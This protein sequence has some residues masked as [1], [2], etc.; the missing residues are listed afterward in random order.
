[1]RKRD[2]P[3]GRCRA[4]TRDS[5]KLNEELGE[6]NGELSRLTEEL[7]FA[8]DYAESI[9][10]SARTPLIILDGALKVRSVNRAF[11]EGFRVT[12]GET[13]GRYIYDLGNR[14]WAIPELRRLLEEV[15]PLAQVIEDYEIRHTF[16]HLGLRIMLLTAR[17]LVQAPAREPLIILSIE[18][19]TERDQGREDALSELNALRHFQKFSALLVRENLNGEVYEHILSTAV[20]LMGA[21]MASMQMLDAD[22]E[23]LRLLAWRGFHPES[24]AH[25]ER[26]PVGSATSCGAAAAAAGRVFVA[27]IESRT[28]LAGTADLAEFRRSGI[29]ACQST[30]LISRAG[31][32]LGMVSTH[33][34]KPH[35]PVE[36][37]LRLL[38][39]LARQA[40][41][42]IERM[43]VQQAL[44]A[45][46][47]R[48]R[49][50]FDL[51]PVAVYSCNTS[52]V[53]EK[54]NSQ[55]AQ[56]WGRAPALG[57][58][59]ERF[60]GSFKMFRPDGSFMTHDQCPMAEVLSGKI[61]E[62]HDGEVLIHR[63]DG[64][65]VTVIVNIRP[66][67]NERGEVVGA[68][69]C[70]YDITERNKGE[71][72]RARLAAIVESSDDAIIGKNLDGIITSWNA[73]AERIF[74]YTAQEIVGQSVTVLIP[75][76]RFAEEAN[77]LGHIRRGE[78]I[79]HF[80][81]VR[82]RKDGTLF[83]VSLTTSPIVD[84]AGR[85]VG[86]SKIARDITAGKR[87]AEALL[88]SEERYRSII[89]SSPDC[90]KVLDLEGNLLSLE[91]GLELLG[92]K[93]I[94]PLL[95][96]SWIEFWKGGEDRA[97]AVAA[98]A[99]AAAGG[100]GEFVG[101][102]RTL[103]GL[104]KWWDVA[105]TPV[106]DASGQPVRLL[107]VSRDVT[108]RHDMEGLLAARTAA[109]VQAD[110]SKDEFLAMLAHE[111]RNPLAPLRNAAEILQAD[112]TTG[113]EREHSLGI[114]TRQIENM[115]RMI[116]DLL[117]VSRITEGKI[118]LRRKPV[119]LEAILTSAASL[120]RSG[121]DARQQDLTLA[122]PAGPIFLNADATRLEQVFG[123][124]LTNACKYGGHGCHISLRAERSGREV[125]VRVLDDGA[126]IAPELLPRI[127]DLFVQSSRTL[128]RE[129]G[130]LG[131]G[132][133]LVKRLVE[134][135][136]G[137][138]EAR[139]EG[140]GKGAEFIVRLPIL[141]EAP[142]VAPL[143]PTP[144]P[145]VIPRRILIVDDN[146][147]SARSLAMLQTRYGH[148][149][150]PAFTGLEALSAAA[151]FLPEVVLLDIGLPGMDGFEVARQIRAMPALAD[152]LLIA[153]TG[154]ASAEDRAQCHAAGFDGHL[155][156]PVDL[157]ILR[158]W[159]TSH[160][161]LAT[162]D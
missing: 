37:D 48:Y 82:R 69:N 14:Q 5:P 3:T 89:D 59:D 85:I 107:A 141:A 53:I 135:H 24:A 149:A 43:Q 42:I 20:A 161:R 140:Q 75:P 155:V 119:S 148:E 61:P 49:D 129:H 124:L 29:R 35:E 144:T 87:A 143:P 33:W 130:G 103:H 99:A 2:P 131:I 34:R 64:S 46:E 115:S 118:E 81:T 98:V 114:L 47:E 102:F 113:E 123:N 28:A 10:A 133:T 128:D 44:R 63:P 76:E 154:Y 26:V 83:D 52:G 151:E 45:S 58:T 121:C 40:A 11:Y 16:E 62:V 15:L 73:G 139:S 68:I 57:D 156:K 39:L 142:P 147:D 77:I 78:P 97:A 7:C 50:L 146:T 134:M 23:Q 158:E 54:F 55:A 70:F 66:L 108:E 109:L 95:G 126:G 79:E 125:L 4:S 84:G 122:L 13:E 110:R 91:A 159:L 138:I 18:D 137:S 101:F 132:L 112:R 106:R 94:G 65:R 145:R 74:G 36:R 51:S 27:D 162:T 32:L 104:D 31:K 25:W 71:E 9:V 88:A 120:A 111:L 90:I 92:I 127:F 17:R 30:P 8:R 136:G 116:D 21:D 100:E 6:R 41:D 60:C 67:K 19:I 160:P 152:T 117:D 12:P 1:M 86:A 93:D 80:E 153:M 38:D 72:A 150:R 56:L 105:V 157:A 96:K 22:S